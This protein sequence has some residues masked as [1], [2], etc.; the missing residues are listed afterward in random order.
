[1]DPSLRL[2]LFLLFWAQVG[3]PKSAPPIM[4]RLPRRFSEWSLGES[5][6]LP[7]PELATVTRPRRS[8]EEMGSCLFRSAREDQRRIIKGRLQQL[9]RARIICVAVARLLTSRRHRTNAHI[10]IA[11]EQMAIMSASFGGDGTAYA[12]VSRAGCSPA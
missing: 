6:P 10:T 12:N 5:N 7:P 11:T 3:S 4:Y 2:L 1:M 8:L 9:A